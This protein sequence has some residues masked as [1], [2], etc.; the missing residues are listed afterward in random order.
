[1]AINIVVKNL[2]TLPRIS[3]L[4]KYWCNFC[5]W[6]ESF[7]LSDNQKQERLK[8]LLRSFPYWSRGHLLLAQLSIKLHDIASAYA[9]AQAV[10]VLERGGT[11]WHQA[12]GILGECYL[13]KSDSRRAISSIETALGGDLGENEKLAFK[14]NLAAAYLLD[15]NHGK[16]LELINAIPVD[17]L[18]ASGVALLRFVR[19]KNMYERSSK[20]K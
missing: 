11:S 15:E 2:L 6:L 19:E 4:A 1:M 13:A 3:S 18:S 16:V 12:H 8:Q 10:L 20:G 17:K 14:E 9:S 5:W 7:R